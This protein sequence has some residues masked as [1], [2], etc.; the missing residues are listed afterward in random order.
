MVI[1]DL[2]VLS[3]E[4]VRADEDYSMSSS[5][6]SLKV[7]KEAYAAAGILGSDDKDVLGKSTFKVC[8]AEVISDYASVKRGVTLIGGPVEKRYALAYLTMIAAGWPFTSDALHQSVVGSW[9]SLM[10]L[11]RPCMSI[12]NEVFGVVPPS[13]VQTERPKLRRLSRK[14]ACELQVASVLAPI[15]VSNLALPFPSRIFATDASMEKGAV[16]EAEVDKKVA[17]AVWR[18]A[19]KRGA[20]VPMLSSVQAVLAAYDP[21]FEEKAISVQ[22]PDLQ[23]QALGEGDIEH[24]EIPRP[25]GLRFQFLEVCGGS[26]VVTHELL[27]LGVVCGPVLDLSTSRQFNLC[28]HRLVE[29]V[30]FLLEDDRLDSVMIA[31]PCTSYSPAA[32]PCVRSYRQPRGFDQS[33]E[34][35]R[36]G[37][38]LAFATLAILMVCLRLAK[39][40][41][42]EQPRRSKMR[43][44]VEWQRLLKMGARETHLASCSFGSIHQKEFALISANMQVDLLHRPCT[45]DHQHVKIEGKWTKPSAIYCE[46][47]A[48]AFANFYKQHLDAMVEARIR[49]DLAA[50][51]LEDLLSNDLLMGLSWKEKSSWKWRG[52]SHINIL[53]L[54]A[55][56]RMLRHVAEE[57]GDERIPYFI[58]S[59]VARC[60][61]SRGRSS[62]GSL[63]R[64]LQ[65]AAALCLAYGLYP[66]GKY[67]PTRMNPA[68]CPTRNVEIPPPAALISSHFSSSQ[69]AALATINGL[70]RWAANWCRLTLL[71]SPA[72]LDFRTF[73]D[74]VRVSPPFPMLS[75]EWH[76]D[77]DATLGYPG[78]G[79]CYLAFFIGCMCWIGFPF[80]IVAVGVPRSHG[81]AARKAARSGI[82]LEAGRRTTELTAVTRELLYGN[83]LSWLEDKEVSFDDVLF[84]SPPD[85]DQLNSLLCDF[86]R[87]LFREGKPYYHFSETI[88]AITCKRPLVRRSLQQSWDLAFMW[89]SHE[90]AEHHIAM[91]FQILIAL[92][93]GAWSWGWKREAACFALAWGALLR[94]GEILA[95]KREDLVLPS[96][97]GNSVDFVLLRIKEPKTR[98]RA[99]RHQAGK[100]EQADLIEVARIGFAE[101]KPF[102]MLWNFSGSTLRSRLQ[103]LLEKLDLPSKNHE[104]PKA[105]SLAS[106]RPGGATHLMSVCESAEL[107]RRRGRWASFRVMEIY[108]QEVA[109]N[110]YLNAV[111]PSARVKVFAGLDAFPLLFQQ[112]RKFDA[113]KIPAATWYFLL[114]HVTNDDKGQ[115]G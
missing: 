65:K 28:E 77:F 41:L 26:G 95:A 62:A 78:E 24:E 81:D 3:K 33:N 14:A 29:W 110:T 80:P 99:A 27:K 70:K 13:V 66:A 75:C 49:L 55:Y 32:Y 38:L 101:L 57:G 54:A 40:A 79:P 23:K 5:V 16:V 88:N 114:S 69:L 111:A 53:E 59:H 64:G 15:M 108:L 58:D 113:C 105:L 9:I 46:G 50:D 21:M 103:R 35:V 56:I 68:D 100:L 90:P 52:S 84:S 87:W 37:N 34:K 42:A 48:I 19:D 72:I 43:W 76:I 71:L 4:E 93:A 18:S 109:A 25:L 97:I 12:F 112:I 86:G 61:I 89:G 107:V 44:L 45:K 20:N 115:M 1:D 10:L 83:F 92:I 51:G 106:F 39:M 85:V 73:V 82:V 104:R 74:S 7:A 60:C 36:I 91:P 11:R 94:I 98:Y 30:L 6:A 102:E 17:E 67:S 2:F 96:D 31:P 22:D 63:R 8:G 47:L